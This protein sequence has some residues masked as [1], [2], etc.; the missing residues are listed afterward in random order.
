MRLIHY[1]DSP[2]LRV[3]SVSQSGEGYEW[4]DGRKPVGL[5]VSVEGD[6]DWREWC[7]A[8]DFRDVDAQFATEVVLAPA[9]RVLVVGTG[10]ALELLSKRYG[11]RDERYGKWSS[12][13]IDWP[14]LAHEHDGIIIA[15]YQW[16]HRL[17][18]EVSGWYYSWDCA[19]GCI[20][21]ADAV[22]GLKPIRDQIAA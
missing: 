21:N 4:H 18:G 5:W 1:S 11:Y 13:R 9:H 8:E 10:V 15:P 12:L 19:S 17:D 2:L 16:K 22:E 14:R 7:R 20:W 3:H 6:D